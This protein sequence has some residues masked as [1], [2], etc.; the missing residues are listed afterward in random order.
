[1]AVLWPTAEEYP[2]ACGGCRRPLRKLPGTRGVKDDAARFE[3]VDPPVNCPGG[4]PFR[5]DGYTTQGL[6]VVFAVDSRFDPHP[7][8]RGVPPWQIHPVLFDEADPIFRRQLRRIEPDTT[9]TEWWGD[10]AVPLDG[11][12]EADLARRRR[13]LWEP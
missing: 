6:A 8:Q 7:P 13:T 11:R 10:D 3:H 1:M 9:G 2:Y 4:R 5:P 12:V